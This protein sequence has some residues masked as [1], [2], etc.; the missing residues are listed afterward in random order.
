MPFARPF[1]RILLAA[2]ACIVAT[3][4]AR[5]EVKNAAPDTFQLQFNERIAGTPSAVYAAI[6]LVERWWTPAHTYSGDASN[7][8]MAMQAGG[9]YCERWKD[10]AV[11]HG[12]VIMLMRD[13][14]VRLEA[15]L[16]PLQNLAVSAVL[17]FLLKEENGATSLT[18]GY[19]V[20]GSSATSRPARHR[21]SRDPTRYRR[22][23]SRTFPPE[24][25]C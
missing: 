20:N 13:Q 8:S 25:P 19:R 5:G 17:T 23:R 7:L 3:G 1:R 4:V 2:M 6:G 22:A 14:V 11:E 10:G 18:V 9:C 24:F 15:T 12:R 21:S 16:G